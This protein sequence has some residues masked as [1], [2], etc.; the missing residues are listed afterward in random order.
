VSG[1]S[2]VQVVATLPPAFGRA[3][4]GLWGQIVDVNNDGKPDF[5]YGVASLIHVR[6]GVGN[7]Q[8]G[9]PIE[10]QVFGQAVSFADYNADGFVD[11]FIESSQGGYALSGK[12]DGT[13]STT[14]KVV[15]SGP[16]YT[17][18]GQT[19]N[20][21]FED[22][23][24][25]GYADLTQ[26]SV[27]RS[28]N[29]AGLLVA[30]YTAPPPPAPQWRTIYGPLRDLHGDGVA[31]FADAATTTTTRAPITV[32]LADCRLFRS[33]ATGYEPSD[34]C[35]FTNSQSVVSGDFNGDGRTDL[36]IEDKVYPQK[37]DGTFGTGVTVPFIARFNVPEMDVN[38]DGST[39][40]VVGGAQEVRV[41]YGSP[42]LAF[43]NVVT[44]PMTGSG[45]GYLAEVS[46]DGVLDMITTAGTVYLGVNAAGGPVAGTIQ[47][48]NANLPT[49][50]EQIYTLTFSDPDGAADIK[51]VDIRGWCNFVIDTTARIVRTTTGSYSSGIAYGNACSMDVSSLTVQAVGATL[52]VSFKM[53]FHKTF[54][55]EFR[56]TAKDAVGFESTE[57]LGRATATKTNA[58][59]VA[60]SVNSPRGQTAVVTMTFDDPN[61]LGD[62]EST[63]L[64]INDTFKVSN[65][66]FLSIRWTFATVYMVNDAG[67]SS[68]G[69]N[70][71]PHATVLANSQCSVDPKTITRQF[72]SQTRLVVSVPITF[73][74]DWTGLKKVFV[75]AID[76]SDASTDFQEKGTWATAEATA[77]PEVVDLQPRTGSGAS[78]TLT[79]TWRHTG[80]GGQH[81]LG[82]ILVLPTP[83]IVQFTAKG[84][85]LVEY[86]RVSHGV[87]LIDDAGTGWLGPQSGVPIGP[88]AGVLSN[89]QCSVNVAQ[90][91]AG[92]SGETMTFIAPLQL[93][94]PMG[95]VLGTFTQSQDV[96][97]KWTGMTQFGNWVLPTGVAQAV[98][99]FVVSMTPSSGAGSSIDVNLTYGHKSGN[100]KTD[101]DLVH[102]RFAAGIT[103]SEYCHVL[104]SPGANALNLINDAGT[105][106]ASA[107][108]VSWTADASAEN[109]R[110]KVERT[111]LTQGA[112]TAPQMTSSFRLTFKP[113]AFGG[114]KN[115]YMNVFD[116]QGR[117]THWVQVGIWNPQ[118]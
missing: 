27:V 53:A 55:Y 82:Y 92:V 17:G 4:E 85:C 74:P 76:L 88:N 114:Q 37:P 102:L 67:T 111:G 113:S 94:A 60:V 36:L 63:D 70:I 71:S 49:H 112:A 68:S 8:F 39:D 75:R 26:A 9:P 69:Q 34:S 59:P 13:F 33:T 22:L 106:L 5:A 3:Q 62:I 18:G 25:D 105:G 79:A 116:H 103:A 64:L 87:R 108:W 97:G 16:N 38:A 6:L 81:Y 31:D 47:P 12:G 50:A 48:S 115:V 7:G 2:V 117:T 32:M 42:S 30:Q 104:Y 83:N 15:D 54:D 89:E 35:P 24:R 51:T 1:D 40:L 20:D 93:K 41:A 99:P 84:T 56:V 21:Y 61:G 45:D 100:T 43:N 52:T 19:R 101:V 66:C 58:A 72:P 109:S 91:L 110:C 11:A 118:L 57:L 23:N 46:G 80:G 95:Q 29:R 86:N 73:S 96:T 107:P 90:V 98:G 28:N 65:A 78:A 14:A 77:G 44:I 10:T